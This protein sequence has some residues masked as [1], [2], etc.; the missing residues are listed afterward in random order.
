MAAYVQ[1][2]DLQNLAAHFLGRGLH[3]QAPRFLKHEPL[4]DERF[5]DLAIEPHGV[6]ELFRELSA[7][8]LFVA[9]FGVRERTLEFVVGDGRAVHAGGEGAVVGFRALSGPAEAH[10]HVD[11]SDDESRNDGEQDPLQL[12]ETFPH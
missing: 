8:H 3:V 6:L 9:L 12:V 2:R 10:V 5:Q 1:G 11:E 4:I 7:I